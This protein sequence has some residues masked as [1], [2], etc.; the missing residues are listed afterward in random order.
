MIRLRQTIGISFREL[1]L[2]LFQ[3]LQ[4][5]FGQ[6]LR[7]VVCELDEMILHIR[8]KERFKVKDTRSASVP[9]LF[10]DVTFKRRYYKDV[11]TKD[12]VH[13]LDEVLGVKAG[14]A[15][16]CLAT[17]AVIQAVIGPSCKSML[18]T[19]EKSG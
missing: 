8:D 15:S 14:Q 7:E 17:A 3:K 9:T 16:P 10:G 12:Y 6:V 1:E 11:E 19:N 5:V 13:L 2:Y 18:K 4:E